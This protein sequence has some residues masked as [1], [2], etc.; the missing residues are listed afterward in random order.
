MN[1]KLVYSDRR[2]YYSNDCIRMALCLWRFRF[3]ERLVYKNT[4]QSYCQNFN[5]I[6]EI[7]KKPVWYVAADPT[8]IRNTKNE[9]LF[10]WN[11][12]CASQWRLII[13]LQ[14]VEMKIILQNI[15][16]VLALYWIIRSML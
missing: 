13:D 10:F 5:K 14:V 3:R 1:F 7:F 11:R 2:Y 9:T 15:T 4:T 6:V 12:W 8:R 16:L